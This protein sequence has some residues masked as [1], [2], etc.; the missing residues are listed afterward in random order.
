[1][2]ALSAPGRIRI[3]RR[4]EYENLMVFY[5]FF[6]LYI[7]IVNLL[8]NNYY[9]SGLLISQYQLYCRSLRP[10]PAVFPG[11]TKQYRQTRCPLF[12][13]L[14]FCIFHLICVHGG[15]VFNALR[16]MR[17]L[18]T[19]TAV[20]TQRPVRHALCAHAQPRCHYVRFCRI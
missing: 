4:D 12:I 3:F 19:P 16:V 2:S 6:P 18:C 13:R 11:S 8:I 10:I 20:D 14:S 15:T 1:M 17:L 7:R 9:L 5:P